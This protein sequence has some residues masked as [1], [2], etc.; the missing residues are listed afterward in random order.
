[1]KKDLFVA[2]ELIGEVEDELLPMFLKCGNLRVVGR[3][4]AQKVEETNRISIV[5]SNKSK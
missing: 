1:M 5:N 2:F 3:S 4:S